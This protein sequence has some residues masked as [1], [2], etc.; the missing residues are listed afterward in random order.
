MKSILRNIIFYASALFVLTQI[1]E[2][3][4]ISGGFFTF[5]LGG[6]VLS[7]IFL[8]IKPVLNLIAL[9]LNIATLGLFSFFSNVIMLYILTVLVPE[10]KINAFEFQGYSFAGFIIPNVALNSFMAYV[11]TAFSLS[12]IVSFLTWLVKK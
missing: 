5:I 2:G 9:P 7:L 3:V 4:K 8:I 11:A 10:I 1:L 12:I 6:A